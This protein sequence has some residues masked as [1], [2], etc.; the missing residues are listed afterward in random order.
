MAYQKIIH[1][2]DLHISTESKPEVSRFRQVAESISKH[3]SGVPVLITGDITNSATKPQM[4]LARSCIEEL[5]KTNLVLMVPGNHDYGALGNFHR[6]A[7]P[8]R[9]NETL[10]TPFGP[11]V[12][13]RR[14]MTATEEPNVEG[15][16]VYEHGHC[17]FVG[18]DSGDPTDKA[19]MARG[20]ITAQLADALKTTLMGHSDRFR[21]VFLHHHP[22]TE[23]MFMEL[24]G[25]DR[26]MASLEGN[27]ELLLFGH[28]HSIGAWWGRNDIPLI[29]ASHKTTKP[30]T[31]TRMLMSVVEMVKTNGDGLRFEHSLKVV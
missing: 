20:I 14:W 3:Y 11:G 23:D 12:Q 13:A 19:A 29:L 17:V 26:L 15:M 21:V 24:T 7:A 4:Q 27:C 1:L 30:I 28:H 18:V 6:W 8:Q 2:S 9:W 5:A 22:F 25:A 31:K 16:G 10:G